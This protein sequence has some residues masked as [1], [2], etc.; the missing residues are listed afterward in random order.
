MK[1]SKAR[2]L[3]GILKYCDC[4]G[5]GN[6]RTAKIHDIRDNVFNVCNRHRREMSVRYKKEA[7]SKLV[8]F[9]NDYRK[10]QSDPV[11]D[12]CGHHYAYIDNLLN[13]NCSLEKKD[14]VTA[15]VELRD[16]LY[17]KSYLQNRVYYPLMQMLTKSL[18]KKHL[19]TSSKKKPIIQKSNK[20]DQQDYLPDLESSPMSRKEKMREFDYVMFQVNCFLCVEPAHKKD[21]AK[22]ASTNIET[23]MNLIKDDLKYDLYAINLDRNDTGRTAFIPHRFRD[24]NGLFRTTKTNT[25]NDLNI[26]LNTSDSVFYTQ[27]S[28]YYSKDDAGCQVAY[29]QYLDVFQIRNSKKFDTTG[30]I[31]KTDVI[32]SRYI[33]NTT[34]M[35]AH[36][37]TNGSEWINVHNDKIIAD[38]LDFRVAI[39]YALAR[40]KY[41]IERCGKDKRKIEEV[42]I[43][44]FDW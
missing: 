25:K 21:M 23:V 16:L 32:Q 44:N 29:Y 39:L 42:L 10:C 24:E 3:K 20:I 31:Q 7:V 9:Y 34:R 2:K 15:Y 33:Y 27:A 18:S 40:I 30:D 6:K 37:R 35:F 22:N 41:F 11:Y 36:V 1:V 8:E 12:A 5:C 38:V 43:S 14:Y 19:R 17:D 28:P 13:I 4:K 26:H